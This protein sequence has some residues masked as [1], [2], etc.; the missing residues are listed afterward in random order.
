MIC[1]LPT[2][3]KYTAQIW[4]IFVKITNCLLNILFFLYFFTKAHGPDILVADSVLHT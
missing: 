3:E 4:K 1:A 2:E